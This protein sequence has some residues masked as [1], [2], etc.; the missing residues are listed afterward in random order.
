MQVGLM[1]VKQRLVGSTEGKLR[2]PQH[3]G[4]GLELVV[5]VFGFLAVPR[6]IGQDQFDLDYLD[7]SYILQPNHFTSHT[8]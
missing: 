3:V 1:H 6:A 5:H 8:S 7:N 4:R 2:S